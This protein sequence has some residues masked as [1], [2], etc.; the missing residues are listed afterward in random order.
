M[1]ELVTTD[2]DRRRVDGAQGRVA[3]Q[4]AG[5]GEAGDLGR[6]AGE[7]LQAVGGDGDVRGRPR[8]RPVPG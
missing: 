7:A 1:L 5:D 4:R 6:E 8:R 3:H 2:A